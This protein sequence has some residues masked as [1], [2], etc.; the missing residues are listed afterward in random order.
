MYQYGNYL[1]PGQYSRTIFGAGTFSWQD[2]INSWKAG[3]GEVMT[4]ENLFIYSK[5]EGMT[6][7]N[8]CHTLVENLLNSL[9]AL[10]FL[11]FTPSSQN[12][13]YDDHL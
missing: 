11:S 5:S 2:P 7:F 10:I 8:I 3:P 6:Q 13:K 12:L 1:Y 4:V 9:I